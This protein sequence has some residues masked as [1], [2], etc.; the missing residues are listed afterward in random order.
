MRHSIHLF[1][2]LC[3]PNLNVAYQRLITFKRLIA[4][5]TLTVD[6]TAL[7]TSVTLQ[8]YAHVST[9]PHS[10]AMTEILFLTELVR[11]ATRYHVI[12]CE[13]IL[14]ELPEP[15]ERYTEY[16][17]IRPKNGKTI[18][19][20]FSKEHNLRLFLTANEPIWAFFETGLHQRKATLDLTETMSDRVKAVLLEGGG[21]RQGNVLLRMSQNN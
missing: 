20:S 21:S 9:I 19:V 14:P 11:L 18:C 17:G 4:L 10:L 6:I 2:S 3:S 16:F 12:P 7:Q 13:V 1:F 8:C 5:M 15:I